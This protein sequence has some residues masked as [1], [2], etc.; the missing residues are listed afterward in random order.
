MVRGEEWKGGLK[1][2]VVGLPQCSGWGAY[3]LCVGQWDGIVCGVFGGESW[4]LRA[5]PR[6][7][8]TADGG[9]VPR[10][11]LWLVGMT[12]RRDGSFRAEPPRRCMLFRKLDSACVFVV[13]RVV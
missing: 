10:V 13:I 9:S 11:S 4:A 2:R 7:R 8:F 1:G 6:A 12:F 3:V 5:L